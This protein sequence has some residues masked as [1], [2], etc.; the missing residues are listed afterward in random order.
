MDVP[1]DMIS[2]ITSHSNPHIHTN[3]HAIGSFNII[4]VFNGHTMGIHKLQKELKCRIQQAQSKP[5]PTKNVHP[6]SN[7]LSLQDACDCKGKRPP[8]AHTTRKQQHFTGDA[9]T[10]RCYKST[11]LAPRMPCSCIIQR[12]A[13][14][15]RFKHTSYCS[16]WVLGLAPKML[17][18]KPALGATSSSSS[19][20]KIIQIC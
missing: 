13:R 10:R 9:T 19:S 2:S 17:P 8:D 4:I 14:G 12:G 3:M 15:V 6:S 16:S 11:T 7:V 1:G 5:A 18:N 20:C